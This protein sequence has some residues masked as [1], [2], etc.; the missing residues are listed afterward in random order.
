M[1]K[2]K[3]MGLMGAMDA[4]Q[5]ADIDTALSWHLRSNHYP[6]V[7]IEMLPVAKLAIELAL[8]E[9]YEA[10]ISL[11]EG[12]QWRGEDTAPVWSVIEN[13]HLD[14]WLMSAEEMEEEDE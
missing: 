14:A 12:V 1:G 2:G 6:P 10:R 13:F 5:Y 11:P 7:P 3:L 8:E 9:D 4:A